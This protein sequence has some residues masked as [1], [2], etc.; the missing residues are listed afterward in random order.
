MRAP[1]QSPRLGSAVRQIGRAGAEVGQNKGVLRPY[2]KV[3]SVPGASAFSIAGVFAR[4]PISMLG[5]SII[6][7]ISQLYGE[8]GIAGRVAAVFIAIKAIC[9]THIA[10]LVEQHGQT[11]ILRHAM[12]MPMTDRAQSVND[13][14]LHT[15]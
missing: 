13:V 7:M 15:P 6:L 4:L 12:W 8:Y 14:S 3:L 2:L 1:R 11:R 10:Q 5:L 9:S